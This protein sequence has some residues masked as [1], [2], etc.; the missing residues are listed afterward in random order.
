MKLFVAMPYGTEKGQLDR[1]DPKPE[2]KEINF[3]D[4]WSG[5]IKP[6]IPPDWEAK[7]ADELRKPGLI[8]QLYTEWLLEADVVLA[9]LTFCN[10]NVYYELGIRQA[11]SRKSTVLI[12][13]KDSKLPFDVR[14][15]EVVHYDY[16]HAPS[17]PKFHA[18]LAAHLTA[19]AAS[20]A[21]SPIHTYLP[22][23]YINRYSDGKTP[24]EVIADLKAEIEKLRVS[25]SIEQGTAVQ[26]ERRLALRSELTNLLSKIT[27]SQLDNAKL[28]KEHADDPG[29]MQL[30]SSTLNQENA[31][32]LNEAT[33]LMERIPDFVGAVEYNTVAFS[34]ANIGEA[35][36]AEA[37]Y[38]RAVEVSANAFE[39]TMAQR[40]FAYFLFTRGRYE[41]ARALYR[42]ALKQLPASD[43][44]SHQT[45]GYTLQGWA[46]SEKH[47]AHNLGLAEQ[48]FEQAQA[49]FEAIENPLLREQFLGGLRAAQLGPQPGPGPHPLRNPAPERSHDLRDWFKRSP[50]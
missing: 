47:V 32:L 21:G 35:I 34:L 43:P 40:S 13:Q 48:L 46:W 22:G 3:D 31:F 44:N 30:V 42:D 14:N 37:Y 18:D 11:L 17:L 4:V 33:M 6:A 16:F 12:A 25:A 49:E 38:R 2:C 9:D 1:D 5:V 27:R 29:Y 7:R 41:E 28:L 50:S 36:R 19:A 26:F 15:Q 24:D 20:P 10:P 39:R 45:N 8:D 23:L